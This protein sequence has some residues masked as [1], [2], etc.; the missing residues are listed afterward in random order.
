MSVRYRTPIGRTSAATALLVLAL[1]LPSAASANPLLSGY[2]GPGQGSQTLIG[3]T[4]V[5]SSGGGSSSG[6]SGSPSASQLTV[7]TS[8]QSKSGSSKGAAK[9]SHGANGKGSGEAGKG[10]PT[11]PAEV[12]PATSLARV[13]SSSSQGT[14]GLS[15]GD[16]LLIVCGLTALVLT[17]VLTRRLTRRTP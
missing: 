16:V 13:T 11:A 4:L 7:T 2:G 5:N 3:S 8:K 9:H 1:A 17:G 15:G 14:L 6:A 10:A 12:V